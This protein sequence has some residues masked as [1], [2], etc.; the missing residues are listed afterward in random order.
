MLTRVTAGCPPFSVQLPG[1]SD[2]DVCLF[3]SVTFPMNCLSPT[4]QL[5]DSR[6]CVSYVCV[7]VFYALLIISCE[8]FL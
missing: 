2:H 7:C 6:V 8:C 1:F 3:V 4:V 5:C